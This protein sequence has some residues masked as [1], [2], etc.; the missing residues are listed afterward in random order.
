M[1]SYAHARRVDDM[2]GNVVGVHGYL[3]V[4][5]HGNLDACAVMCCFFRSHA[6]WRTNTQPPG[7]CHRIFTMQ[8]SLVKSRMYHRL[9]E[10]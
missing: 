5:E 2:L 1:V 4:R 8:Y 3:G 10:I 9:V 7:H 6:R